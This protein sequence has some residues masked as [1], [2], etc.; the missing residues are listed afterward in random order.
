MVLQLKVLV[1]RSEQVG[2][3]GATALAD[4]LAAEPPLTEL[5][6]EGNCITGAGAARLFEALASNGSMLTLNLTDNPAATEAPDV[7][8]NIAGVLRRNWCRRALWDVMCARR[9]LEWAKGS[10]HT[11]GSHS[12]YARLPLDLCEMVSDRLGEFQPV[13]KAQPGRDG[14]S[15]PPPKPP[16]RCNSVLDRYAGECNGAPSVWTSTRAPSRTVQLQSP[17]QGFVERFKAKAET[18]A[19]PFFASTLVVIL[20]AGVAWMVQS[21]WEHGYAENAA[22]EQATL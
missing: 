9:R 18:D 1:D 19:L 14:K 4:A 2:D 10:H 16:R 12:A 5:R 13:T 3:V 17:Q 11:L 22:R 21:R 8:T 7:I 20:F 15:R 6:L